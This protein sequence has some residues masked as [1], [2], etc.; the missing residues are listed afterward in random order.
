MFRIKNVSNKKKISTCW[1]L[2]FWYAAKH[3][4]TNVASPATH[5]VRSDAL[6]R[7][8]EWRQSFLRC[9]ARDGVSHWNRNEP[10]RA[11]VV[12]LATNVHV[13]IYPRHG[14]CWH[15]FAWYPATLWRCPF[16]LRNTRHGIASKGKTSCVICH[17]SNSDNVAIKATQHQPAC[18]SQ[19]VYRYQ[20]MWHTT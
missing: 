11:A 4:A 13:K 2:P 3:V 15:H 1:C 17:G 6:G 7:Q 16:T 14:P 20:H 19:W 8:P 9:S 18:F 12:R 10:W 5:C